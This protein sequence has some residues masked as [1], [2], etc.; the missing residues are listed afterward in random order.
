MKFAISAKF[1]MLVSVHIR[2]RFVQLKQIEISGEDW[3]GRG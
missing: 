3:Q 2:V 1:Q